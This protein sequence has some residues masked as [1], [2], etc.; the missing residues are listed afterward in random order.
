MKTNVYISYK[1]AIDTDNK[2]EAILTDLSKAF[3][4]LDHLYQ[5]QNYISMD[6]YLYFLSLFCP[7]S[8]IVPMAIIFNRLKIEHG[9][10]QGPISGLLY[11]NIN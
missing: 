4:C 11:F 1:E 6:F 9:V 7:I 3:D 8:G 5:L 10:P 2:F